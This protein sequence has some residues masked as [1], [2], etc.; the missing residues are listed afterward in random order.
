M[1]YAI[2]SVSEK[3]K[4]MACV[5]FIDD[6]RYSRIV[7]VHTNLNTIPKGSIEVFAIIIRENIL[8]LSAALLCEYFESILTIS[9]ILHVKDKHF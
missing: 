3:I 6:L 8:L 9:T 2:E 5:R 7:Q 4:A 1:K